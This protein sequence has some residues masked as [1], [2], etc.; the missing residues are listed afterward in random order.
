MCPCEFGSAS[1]EKPLRN[2][3]GVNVFN[4]QQVLFKFTN[5]ALYRSNVMNGFMYKR[6]FDRFS[7]RAGFDYLEQSYRYEQLSRHFYSMTT[8]KAYSKNILLGIESSRD[9]GKIQP[10]IFLDALLGNSRYNGILGSSGDFNPDYSESNYSFNYLATGG[11]TGFGIK[12][13][14][15]RHF[16]ITAE[17]SVAIIYYNTYKT[18]NFTPTSSVELIVNPLR[19]LTLNYHF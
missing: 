10:Y 15:F 13:R 3:F 4:A 6:H 8:G 2:E 19:A 5:Q 14:P 12:Y 16:S 1:G 17:T 7:L 11:F 18:S 9:L